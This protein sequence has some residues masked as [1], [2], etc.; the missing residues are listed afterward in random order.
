MTR[1]LAKLWLSHVTLLTLFISGSSC[2]GSGSVGTERLPRLA[3]IG[4]QAGG[5]LHSSQCGSSGA[6]VSGTVLAPNGTDP[7]PTATVYVTDD[8]PTPFSSQVQCELC[9]TE[10]SGQVNPDEDCSRRD[11]YAKQC[12][13]RSAPACHPERSLPPCYSAQC[14]RSEHRQSDSRPN[15]ATKVSGRAES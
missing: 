9:G 5:S 10:L 13:S 15:Q 14:S 4:D 11:L 8:V 12:L 1:A 2:G 7:V 6:M 3:P